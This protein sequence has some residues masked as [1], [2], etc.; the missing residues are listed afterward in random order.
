MLARGYVPPIHT[1][2]TAAAVQWSTVAIEHAG[3]NTHIYLLIEIS[4]AGHSLTIMHHQRSQFPN[5]SNHQSPKPAPRNSKHSLHSAHMDIDSSG[6]CS[7]FGDDDS[8]EDS[9][10]N[11][12]DKHDYEIA[13]DIDTVQDT[14]SHRSVRS[15][16]C[17]SLG[18][19]DSFALTHAR[20]E[21]P[22]NHNNSGSGSAHYSHHRN[23][24]YSQHQQQ[25]RQRNQ[26]PTV[27]ALSQQLPPVP[28]ILADEIA[29]TGTSQPHQQQHQPQQPQSSDIYHNS[30]HSALKSPVKRLC[31]SAHRRSRQ[32]EKIALT[33][34]ATGE[35]SQALVKKLAALQKTKQTGGPVKK[36]RAVVRSASSNQNGYY[37]G[38]GTSGQDLPLPPVLDLSAMQVSLH[39]QQH[40]QHQQHQQQSPKSLK[41]LSTFG[42]TLHT[43][44]SHSRGHNH[45]NQHIKMTPKSPRTPKSPKKK[46]R[47]F[48]K[49]QNHFNEESAS[50]R[51]L[52]KSP[53]QCQA[54]NVW[55]RSCAASPVSSLG[56]LSFHGL[57]LSP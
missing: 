49:R 41:S 40:Q 45:R 13:L 4:K 22:D 11:D 27:S 20:F 26:R 46:L 28:N 55:P 56:S 14:H 29:T 19:A 39:Q 52:P 50:V 24:N 48:L 34:S 37:H 38:S 16:H 9:A 10:M 15:F 6:N 25:Q 44:S 1:V 54:V 30:Q 23:G 12:I 53:V 43:K 7:F 35:L 5:R 57:D 36:L 42:G 8:N 21:H 2:P 31:T 47:G 17:G 33:D 18:T 51:M 3:N 32:V